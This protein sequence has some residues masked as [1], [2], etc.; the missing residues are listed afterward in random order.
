M[1]FEGDQA[2]AAGAEAA[3][4]WAGA[5]E[6]PLCA[7]NGAGTSIR[8][9]TQ[10][11]VF[12]NSFFLGKTLGGVQVSLALSRMEHKA[13]RPCRGNTATQPS[14]FDSC[15]CHVPGTSKSE[16]FPCEVDFTD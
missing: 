1:S 6:A 15:R 10:E 11:T 3:G 9:T 13:P 4:C 16:R 8:N 2:G 14:I 7:N 12:I 5:G